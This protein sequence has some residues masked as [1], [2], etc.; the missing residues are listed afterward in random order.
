M[1]SRRAFRG[2]GF[3]DAV[4]DARAARIQGNA[5]ASKEAADL[6]AAQTCG[7]EYIAKLASQLKAADI[8]GAAVGVATV[9]SDDFYLAAARSKCVSAPQ[10]RAVAD[11]SNQLR[12]ALQSVI[13]PAPTVKDMMIDGSGFTPPGNGKPG[14]NPFSTGTLGGESNLPLILG[15]LA[16]AAGAVYFLRKK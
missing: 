14:F 5:I 3:G 16:L 6:T 9:G 13:A 7:D 15:G 8:A 2:F 12:N 4:S 10:I 1:I 11:A